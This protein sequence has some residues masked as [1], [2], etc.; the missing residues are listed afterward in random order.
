MPL[1]I[2][3]ITKENDDVSDEKARNDDRFYELPYQKQEAMKI[4]W[5]ILETLNGNSFYY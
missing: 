5:K 2:T 4:A 1:R 3:P